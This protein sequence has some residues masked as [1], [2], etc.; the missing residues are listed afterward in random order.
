MLASI[1]PG[2]LAAVPES[3]THY[4]FFNSGKSSCGL[5]HA[6]QEEKIGNEI[7][8]TSTLEYEQFSQFQSTRHSQIVVKSTTPP[9][10]LGESKLTLVTNKSTLD[11]R[12]DSFKR[13]WHAQK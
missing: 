9:P 5:Q 10:C 3:E 1:Y 12:Y 7:G 8:K 13:Y 4:S 11:Q 6:D 2:L